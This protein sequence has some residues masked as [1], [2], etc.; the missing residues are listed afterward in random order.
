[1]RDNRISGTPVV[2]DGRLVGMISIEDLINAL[3]NNDIDAP[4]GK[5]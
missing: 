1:M 5:R 4:S 3:L 2:E